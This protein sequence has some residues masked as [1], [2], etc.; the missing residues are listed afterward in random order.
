MEDVEKV[1]EELYSTL[2]SEYK[3]FMESMVKDKLTDETKEAMRKI[4][5]KV[6][7]KF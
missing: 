7:S 1:E 6:L 3:E 2:D 4:C 5:K